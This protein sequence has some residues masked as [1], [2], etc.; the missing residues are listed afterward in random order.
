MESP[1]Q[2]PSS[3]GF[4]SCLAWQN[5]FLSCGKKWHVKNS[6]CWKHALGVATSRWGSGRFTARMAAKG[7]GYCQRPVCCLCGWQEIKAVCGREWV[8]CQKK[9][10][11]RK[12]T[13]HLLIAW[14][15]SVC[16]NRSTHRGRPLFSWSWRRESCWWGIEWREMVL[17]LWYTANLVSIPYQVN[18][19]PVFQQYFQSLKA[20]YVADLWDESSIC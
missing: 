16:F 14:F 10:V 9:K 13:G 11:M 1:P 5:Q 19:W 2:P 3:W 15:F 18:S 4:K 6:K 8:L 20:A 7:A 17:V 12:I